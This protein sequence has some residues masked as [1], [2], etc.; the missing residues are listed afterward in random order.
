VIA[1]TSDEEIARLLIGLARQAAKHAR[2]AHDDASQNMFLSRKMALMTAVRL[3]LRGTAVAR[4]LL[5]P[6]AS[7]R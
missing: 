7:V 4:K 2:H 1:K 5:A 6:R 3:I